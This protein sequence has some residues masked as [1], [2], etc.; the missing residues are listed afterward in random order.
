MTVCPFFHIGILVPDLE[1]AQDKF[2]RL[3]GIS[4]TAVASAQY[5]IIRPESG[6]RISR[7][8]RMCYSTDGPPHYELMQADA[9]DF[10][11]PPE[12][13]RIHHVG[14]WTSDV[15]QAQRQVRE[16]G[17]RTDAETRDA[18][19]Q[20]NVFFTNPQDA[21]GIRFEFLPEAKRAGWEKFIASRDPGYLT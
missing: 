19:G 9:S 11:G 1:E 12:G 16:I 8:S 21:Y 15:G 6:T 18:L 5:E 20:L 3:F 13:M 14:L 7:S 10:F 4:F 2:T 17:L